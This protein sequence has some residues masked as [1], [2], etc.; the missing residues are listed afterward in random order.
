MN[1][2]NLVSYGICALLTEHS[3]LFFE[4]VASMMLNKKGDVKIYD[5]ANNAIPTYKDTSGIENYS[6][7][8]TLGWKYGF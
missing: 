7:T 2:V 4:G 5:P 8:M 3:K 6:Y 1:K